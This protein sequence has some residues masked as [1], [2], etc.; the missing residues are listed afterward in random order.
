MSDLWSRIAFRYAEVSDDVRKRFLHPAVVEAARVDSLARH[1]CLDYGCGPGDVSAL[2][3]GVFDRL[4]LMDSAKGAVREA[5]RRLGSRVTVLDK[6]GFDSTPE[7]FDMIILSMVLTTMASDTEAKAL[8][9]KLGARLGKNGRLILATTHPC[10][11]FQ[12]LSQQPYSSSGAPYRVQIEPG[13]EITEYHRPLGTVLDLISSS[14]LRIVRT[15]EVYDD[16]AYYRLRGEEPH[17][18]AGALP[19]FLTLT[20]DRP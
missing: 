16:P 4:V 12:A 3:I 6:E 13:L 17:R 11:T 19:M 20:C 9:G 8:L 1:S 7:S 10:F 2:L 18:F 5:S 14:G 15:R